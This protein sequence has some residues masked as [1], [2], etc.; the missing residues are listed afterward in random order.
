MG[1]D[2]EI[3]KINVAYLH[4]WL[5]YYMSI[6]LETESSPEIRQPWVQKIAPAFVISVALSKWLNSWKS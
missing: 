4:L 1:K 6:A 5:N 2:K 3:L